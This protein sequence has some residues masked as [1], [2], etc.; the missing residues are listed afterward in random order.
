MGG[1]GITVGGW[2]CMKEIKIGGWGVR[3]SPPLY[4]FKWSSPNGVGEDNG[5][6]VET[7]GLTDHRM[8][9]V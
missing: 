7:T 1:G 5:L 6:F 9:T 4:T 2:G 8:T 3:N